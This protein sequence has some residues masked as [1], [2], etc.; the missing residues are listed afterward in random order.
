MKRGN[1]T[2][3]ISKLT[4]L[5]FGIAIGFGL[6]YRGGTLNLIISLAFVIITIILA[7]IYKNQK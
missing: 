6:G 2:I 3:R 5:F 7:L 1:K 4:N